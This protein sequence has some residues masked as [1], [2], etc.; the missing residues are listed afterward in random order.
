MAVDAEVDCATPI[1]LGRAS[2]R[3]GLTEL[4]DVFHP[5]LRDYI[6][7]DV[8]RGGPPGPICAFVRRALDAGTLHYAE[9][10]LD[11]A[12]RPDA[13]AR[14]FARYLAWFTQVLPRDSDEH[15]ALVLAFP[16]P[17]EALLPTIAAAHLALRSAVYDQ[18]CTSAIFYQDP[19]EPE[20]GRRPEP[21][22]FTA[23]AP[24]YVLRRIVPADF[25]MA[26]RDPGMFPAY[27]RLHAAEVRRTR[28]RSD[29]ERERWRSACQR[30]H[31]A[32]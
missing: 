28:L 14:A 31:L 27:H 18:G 7:A 11:S 9:L 5:Y 30:H 21:A 16:G 23:P 25:Q 22:Y 32:S 6:G 26:L 20:D 29:R 15:A 13:L 12:T 24:F 3:T 19:A 17:P 4:A 1:V 10:A 8:G 2:E